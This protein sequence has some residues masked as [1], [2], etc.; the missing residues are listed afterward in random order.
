VID[1]SECV[2][3]VGGEQ[4]AKEMLTMFTGMLD[5]EFIPEI[6]KAY[7]SKDDVALRK[8]IHKFLGSVCYIGAPALK[9]ATLNFQQAVKDSSPTLEKTLQEFLQQVRVFKYQ[10]AEFEKITMVQ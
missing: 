7:E 6:S 2:A 3:L 9:Q 5:S 1:F 4:R 10:V 8:A